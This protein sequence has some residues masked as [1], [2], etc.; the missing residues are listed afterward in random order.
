MVFDLPQSHSSYDRRYFYSSGLVGSFSFIFLM[1][2][3]KGLSTYSGA[4]DEW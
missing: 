4:T 3:E 2:D 1:G